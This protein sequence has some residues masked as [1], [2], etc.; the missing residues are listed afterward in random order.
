MLGGH[1]VSQAFSLC[2]RNLS[3]SASIVT[4]THW[5]SCLCVWGCGRLHGPCVVGYGFLQGSAG[6][7]GRAR[8]CTGGAPL[9]GHGVSFFGSVL[10]LW[11][12]VP[13]MLLGFLLVW[14]LLRVR[15][16]AW[17]RHAVATGC[18]AVAHPG[19]LSRAGAE[20]VGCAGGR[21]RD[22]A[23]CRVLCALFSYCVLLLTV[24]VVCSRCS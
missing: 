13:G 24:R 16:R 5:P 22:I 4:F 10:A 1:G 17:C 23:S 2:H 6:I 21:W 12:V 11:V 9:V 15:C 20:G 3:F 18:A 14:L 8:V 7:F 19:L